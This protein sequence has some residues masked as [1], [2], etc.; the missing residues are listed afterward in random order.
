MSKRAAASKPTS[1]VEIDE[2]DDEVAAWDRDDD[3]E[4]EFDERAKKKEKV[5]GSGGAAT[6][7]AKKVVKKTSNAKKSFDTAM[8]IP[9]VAT[10]LRLVR[11]LPRRTIMNTDILKQMDNVLEVEGLS[12]KSRVFAPFRRV[13]ILPLVL[14]LCRPTKGRGCTQDRRPCGLGRLSDPQR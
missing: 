11:K 4:F 8:V 7:S 13:L 12:R 3:S 14:V 9:D 2:D 10:V 6:S 1:Y 5:V